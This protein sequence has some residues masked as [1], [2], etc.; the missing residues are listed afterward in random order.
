EEAEPQEAGELPVVEKLESGR[1]YLQVGAYAERNGAQAAVAQLGAEYPVEVL[2]EDTREGE[3][4][5][6][7]RVLVGPLSED[8]RGSVL[9]M[10]RAKG[11]RD[12]FIRRG[13]RAGRM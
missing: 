5:M 7:Y 13:P 1:F 3:D 2:T 11:Y 8:E 4:Q 10:V 9:Y 12:A 6:L